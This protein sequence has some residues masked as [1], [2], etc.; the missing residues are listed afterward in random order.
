[1]ATTTKLARALWI[2]PLTLGAGLLVARSRPPGGTAPKARRPWF[3]LGFLAA[4]A[5]VTYI[6][7]L[8]PAG[9]VL[10]EIAR[11]SLVLTLFLLGLG[12]SRESLARVGPRPLLHGVL[13]WGLVGTGTLAGIRFGWIH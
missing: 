13:L 10:S 11:R 12:L 4:A 1:M 5:L 3:I 8:Q 6:P 2:L 9:R 7:G